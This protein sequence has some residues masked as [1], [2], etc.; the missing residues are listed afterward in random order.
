MVL[1]GISDQEPKEAFVD[2]LL[3]TEPELLQPILA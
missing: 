1:L 2:G 3:F